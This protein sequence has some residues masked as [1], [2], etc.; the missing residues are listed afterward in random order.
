MLPIV[1]TNVFVIEFSSHLPEPKCIVFL[2][3]LGAYL[4]G[5]CLFCAWAFFPFKELELWG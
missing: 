4:A 3:G 5:L 2:R 1:S